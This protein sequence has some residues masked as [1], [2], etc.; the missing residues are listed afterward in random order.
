MPKVD[1][2]M[3]CGLQRKRSPN[4]IQVGSKLWPE[5]ET[6]SEKTKKVMQQIRRNIDDNKYRKGN[7][8]QL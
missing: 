4:G 5:I 7:F 1:P 2:K 6:K 3:V 8:R